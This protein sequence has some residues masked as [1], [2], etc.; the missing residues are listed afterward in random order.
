M[1]CQN[2][3]CCGG[4]PP[5]CHCEPVD[6]CETSCNSGCCKPCC[7]PCP[8]ICVRP[9]VAPIYPYSYYGYGSINLGRY[10]NQVAYSN[11]CYPYPF[12]GPYM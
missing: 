8:E 7:P 3:T 9:C 6:A 5:P 4:T 10:V 11:V 1:T 2:K 12:I